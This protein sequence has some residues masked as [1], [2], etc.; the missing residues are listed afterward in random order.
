[1]MFASIAISPGIWLMN[2]GKI[3]TEKLGIAE[4]ED[5]SNAVKEGTNKEI[6]EEDLLQGLAASARAEAEAKKEKGGIDLQPALDHPQDLEHPQERANTTK[7]EVLK[8][9][10]LLIK[11]A[12]A[13][14]LIK[15]EGAKLLIENEGA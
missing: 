10:K 12:G 11:N 7:R 9:A 3:V 14:L 4:K 5:A 13:K 8:G 15:N 1:M 6:A 2:A